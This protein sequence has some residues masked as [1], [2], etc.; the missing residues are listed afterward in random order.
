MPGFEG[1][2]FRK[3]LKVSPRKPKRM[4]SNGTISYMVNS[5][6]NNNTTAVP[7]FG[8]SASIIL[9][10]AIIL[11]IVFSSKLKFARY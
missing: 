6:L 7:E 11:I 9:V 2:R 4:V 3:W 10:T 1:A 8:P 5:T